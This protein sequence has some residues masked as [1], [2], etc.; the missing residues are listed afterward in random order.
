MY[1]SGQTCN[2]NERLYIVVENFS[3]GWYVFL[4]I[5]ILVW[6]IGNSNLDIAC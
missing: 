5:D 3:R 4:C 6:V 1:P 2:S